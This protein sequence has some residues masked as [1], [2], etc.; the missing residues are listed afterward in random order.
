MKVNHKIMKPTIGKDD[1]N[2]GKY[3]PGESCTQEP[4]VY[5]Y[6][7]DLYTFNLI[8]TPGIGDT[9]GIQYDIENMKM[10]I[11]CLSLSDEV[12]GI[13]LLLKP[14]SHRFVPPLRY[15]LEELL[16]NLHQS[17][18]PNISVVFTNAGSTLYGYGNTLNILKTFVKE[19]QERSQ[20]VI[21]LESKNIFCV[22]NEAIGVIY[23]HYK[24]ETFKDEVIVSSTYSWN[25]SVKETHRIF[26]Y[27]TS[28]TPHSTNATK[29]TNQIRQ[30]LWELYTIL[31]DLNDKITQNKKI[32]DE[33][34]QQLKDLEEHLAA[35]QN[36]N[37]QGVE[38]QNTR[39]SNPTT[40]CCGAKCTEQIKSPNSCV[41]QTFYK[42]SCCLSC[43]LRNVN[44]NQIGH[45]N[46]RQCTIFDQNANCKSCGCSWQSH[47]HFWYSQKK[48]ETQFSHPA[49]QEEIN[50]LKLQIAAKPNYMQQ[51]KTTIYNFEQSYK[52][53]QSLCRPF[54]EFLS[55]N[56]I[57]TVNTAFEEY[58]KRESEVAQNSSKHEKV[59][60]ESLEKLRLIHQEQ[61]FLIASLKGADTS[62][63]QKIS[64]LNYVEKIKSLEKIGSQIFD[65]Q[66]YQRLFKR[67]MYKLVRCSTTNKLSDTRNQLSEG[68]PSE[69]RRR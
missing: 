26:D 18:I 21:P 54:Y 3:L 4:K 15:C 29:A 25:H 44:E 67:H 61:Q 2:E 59:K 48:I 65:S 42:Q 39:L 10:V 30:V 6:V 66:N 57:I 24:G 38:V 7:T 63:D 5:R 20:N 37:Y 28:L 51:L 34:T 8:D 53:V 43:H 1:E 56:S 31:T 23:G 47:M 58:L 52:S 50:R 55:Q 41:L 14:D 13:C 69:H 35:R 46:L 64:L 40:V 49:N 33:Q 12:H 45:A 60:L 9:R 68:S 27:F 22:D 62:T 36:V 16:A 32:L 17:S 19:V 11:E